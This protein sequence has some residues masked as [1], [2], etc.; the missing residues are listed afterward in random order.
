MDREERGGPPSQ[1]SRLTLLVQYGDVATGE[2]DGVRSTEARHW[3]QRSASACR[4]VARHSELKDD[5]GMTPWT[6][7]LPIAGGKGELTAAAHD[8]DT[9]SHIV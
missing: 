8:N 1:A 5:R 9:G 6:D 7:E 2:V 3:G 4:M